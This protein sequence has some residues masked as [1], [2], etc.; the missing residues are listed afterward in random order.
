MKIKTKKG[1]SIKT[2]PRKAS[3]RLPQESHSKK[4]HSKKMK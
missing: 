1:G 4:G 3:Y 2:R